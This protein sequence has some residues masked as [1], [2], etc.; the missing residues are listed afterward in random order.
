METNIK[1]TKSLKP[2]IGII[3]VIIISIALFIFAA[4]FNQIF[5]KIMSVNSY[6]TWH[7]I[8]EFAS[9]LV[10]FSIFTVTFFI[11]EESKSLKMI[12]LGCAFLTMGSLDFLHT[13]S[14]KGMSHFFIA[15]TSANRATT[16]W[17]ISRTLGSF[18]F[19]AT[20]II[21]TNVKSN[22]K[23][24]NF[25]IIT[26]LILLAIFLT[27]TYFP[28]FIPEMFIEGQG[29]TREKII[30]E[31][32]IIFVMS[33]TLL[34]TTIEYKDTKRRREYLFI[35][36]LIFSIFSELAFVSYANVY[37]AYNYLGHLY[38]FIAYMILYKAIYIE[39]VSI[40]YREMIKVKNELKEYSENLNFIVKQRTK[41]LEEANRLLMNDIEYAKEMQR[42]FLPI[43]M[44]QDKTVT[45]NARYIPAKHLSGDF[46]NVLRLDEKNIGIYIGDVSGHGVS[47]AMLTIFANQNIKPTT[48]DELNL[49]IISPGFVLKN[50]YKSFNK[51]NFK[52]E[53]YIVMLYGVFNTKERTFTYASAGINV[54]PIIIKKNGE[55]IEM[56]VKGFPICKLGDYFMPYF[57][58]RT[59]QLESGDKIVFY[60]DGLVESKNTNK[61]HILMN[62][63]E[64]LQTNFILSSSELEEIIIKNFYKHMGR[65]NKLTDDV[66]LLILEVK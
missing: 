2:I 6:L 62:I 65:N 3:S 51:T 39:N 17:I 30:M 13:L 61:N 22:I 41:E 11:Y 50:L 66:T 33:I 15:N 8:F 38:K 34:I 7:I 48:D 18:G 21:P 40:P 64:L 26:S 37:D 9:V 20:V 45:F 29:L 16:F 57:D 60:T 46:Y 44:P 59:V 19:L 27:V 25:V 5:I 32:I 4:Y 54:S 12:I 24:K 28:K 56:N 58:D 23:K 10:S 47:A 55:I 52:T 31:F 1:A 35:I 14:F 42:L 43:Q 36:A 49:E 53:T 63:N